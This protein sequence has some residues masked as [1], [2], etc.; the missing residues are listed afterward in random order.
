MPFVLLVLLGQMA[1]AVTFP[2][3]VA[4][5]GIGG[6]SNPV[7]TTLHSAFG[8][9]GVLAIKYI[10]I[11]VMVL[12]AYRLRAHHRILL[13]AASI[14]FFGAATNIIAAAA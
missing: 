11:A 1:D 3:G 10:A 5:V 2:L 14:G 7:I 13:V 8:M 9:D 6:E 4:V 12:L